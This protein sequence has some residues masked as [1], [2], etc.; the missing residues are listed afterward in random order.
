MIP[1]RFSYPEHILTYDIET[2]LSQTTLEASTT[3]L[4]QEL[5]KAMSN[6]P[7]HRASDLSAGF[8]M[9]NCH[10]V[11]WSTDHQSTFLYCNGLVPFQNWL[12]TDP[13]GNFDGLSCNLNVFNSKM[14][15]LQMIFPAKV[16]QN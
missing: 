15:Y 16:F 9:V 12:C 4:S 1:D 5:E 2:H 6:L 11:E 14:D 8:E 10:S 3:Q 13:I 7:I